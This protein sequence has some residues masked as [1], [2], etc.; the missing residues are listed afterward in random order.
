M[1]GFLLVGAL[2]IVLLVLSLLLGDLL[3]G[4]HLGVL[5][6]EF[7][8]TAALAGF[9]GAFGFTG[10][11]LLDLLHSQP[12]AIGGGLAAG[13]AIGALVGWAT[14]RLK[15]Q[16]EGG[17]PSTSS[18][19]GAQGVVISAV[20]AAG[21]GEVRIHAGGHPLKIN[22]RC[23]QPLGEGTRVWVSDV[24]SATAVEVRPVEALEA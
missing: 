16:G 4:L 22:A 7:F 17:V 8:S 2:G 24:L 21:Y 11:L 18:L 6:S 23:E 1:T 9:I 12:I 14:G 3:D 19:R 10:A 20:P 13:L 5:D 15:N